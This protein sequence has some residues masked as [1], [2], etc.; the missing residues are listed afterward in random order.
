MQINS[1]VD[2]ILI[3]FDHIDLIETRRLTF[4]R[5]QIDRQQYLILCPTNW[6][7]A[8]HYMK[9]TFHDSRLDSWGH[10]LPLHEWGKW[11]IAFVCWEGHVVQEQESVWGAKNVVWNFSRHCH[12]S[13]LFKRSRK[14]NL[15]TGSIGA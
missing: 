6:R 2:Q 14:K 8:L 1:Y 11:H 4:Y 12:Y 15:M 10:D 13:H 5:D 9:E 7:P 3:L